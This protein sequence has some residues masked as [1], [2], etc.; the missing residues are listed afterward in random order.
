MKDRLAIERL[1]KQKLAEEQT[2]HTN[3]FITSRSH[4]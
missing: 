3:E 1:A 4:S 2:E